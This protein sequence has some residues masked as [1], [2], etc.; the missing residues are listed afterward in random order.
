MPKY[1]VNE[2]FHGSWGKDINVHIIDLPNY[3]KVGD[4]ENTLEQRKTMLEYSCY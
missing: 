2:M 3:I 1:F 4:W